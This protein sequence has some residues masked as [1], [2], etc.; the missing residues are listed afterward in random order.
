MY[1]NDARLRNMTYG[2]TIHYDVE[3]DIIYYVGE[4]KKEVSMTL[5]KIYLGRFPIMLHSNL[6][7]LRG[8][9]TEARFNLGECRNDF[10]GYFIIDGKEK[11]ILSQEKF[12]DNMLYVR[13]NKPDDLYSYSCEVHSVSEDSSK[14]IR[15][16]SVKIIA[17]DAVYTNNQIV[18]DIPNIKKPVPLFILMRALGVVSDKDIIQTCLLTNL[19]DDAENNKNPYIDLFIPS[20][21]DA[22]KFFNQQ[23]ALEF[24]AELTKLLKSEDAIKAQVSDELTAVGKAFAAPRRTRIGAA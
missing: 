15:Y 14:P 1:P 4:E 18:V 24:I 6:C 5:E 21:H 23:N 12:A 20:I 19:D 10:G 13:K 8:L 3:V 9:S 2:M 11:C 16:S 22:N 17:P 7:I